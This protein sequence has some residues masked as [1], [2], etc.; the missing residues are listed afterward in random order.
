MVLENR[1]YFVV[2]AFFFFSF[3]NNCRIHVVYVQLLNVVI[4]II[5]LNRE[6]KKNTL[7]TSRGVFDRPCLLKICSDAFIPSV[8]LYICKRLCCKWDV[9]YTFFWGRTRQKC[10]F[11]M[12]VYSPLLSPL[13]EYNVYSFI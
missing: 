13:F 1:S 3:M 6:I 8:Q 9:F 12:C 11:S 5:I 7:S 2:M 4:L 10:G